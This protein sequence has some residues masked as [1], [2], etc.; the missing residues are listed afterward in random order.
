[1]VNGA[2][3]HYE[4]RG[5]G[6]PL[7]LVHGTG[8]YADIWSPVLDGLARAYRVIAY[9]RRGFA[10]SS[11][12][13]GGGLAEHARDAAAL[14]NALGASPAT[15]VGWSGGGVIA[16][17]LAA[18]FPDCVAALVL[19]E[20]AVHLTTHPRRAA[21]AMTARSNFHRY[22]RRDPASA[23][24]TMYRWASGYK[25]GGN[26]FDALPAAWREQMLHH[27]PATLRE[28]DQMIRPYPTRAAIRSI[29]CPVTVI[30]GDLSDP[31]FATADGFVMR[32]LPQ[33]RMVSLR[34]AAHMLHIDQPEG[35]VEVVTQTTGHAPSP[36]AV[37]SGHP[38]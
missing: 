31:A 13:L 21:L 20:P 30:E 18:S 1:M 17:D 4:E 27:A 33:A 3:L 23:A 26:A 22:V 24:L 12:A 25:T 28:M 15:V 34:G 10:R 7:L 11:P 9:D 6:P 16:L 38:Q 37:P 14:L 5:S 36:A 19:A 29:A 35:W 2:V 8:A 32:L